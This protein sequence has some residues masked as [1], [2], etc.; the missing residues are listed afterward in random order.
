MRLTQKTGRASLASKAAFSLVEVLVGM[1]VA[2]IMLASLYAGFS[3]GFSITQ[4]TRENLRATQIMLEKTEVLRLYSWS[5]LHQPGFIPAKFTAP[6]YS[7]GTNSSGIVY[8]GKITFAP[9]PFNVSYSHNMMQVS[10]DVTWNSS[11]VARHRSMTTI[12]ARDGLQNY[13]Y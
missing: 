7:A 13:L 2:G 6:Y 3:S 10:I 5:Q 12:I 11:G 9:P 4:A 8:Y 1:G